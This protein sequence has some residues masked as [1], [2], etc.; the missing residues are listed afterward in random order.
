MY[1]ELDEIR[2]TRMH[3]LPHVGAHLSSIDYYVYEKDLSNAYTDHHTS[4]S[5]RH[6]LSLSCIS[7]KDIVHA[8][9]E[10][11]SLFIPCTTCVMKANCMMKELTTPSSNTANTSSHAITGAQ[12]VF[13]KKV[14]LKI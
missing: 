7:E 6:H 11:Q 12:S 14:I 2:K 4:P 8:N 13:S 5:D 9:D 10:R 1:K 3:F